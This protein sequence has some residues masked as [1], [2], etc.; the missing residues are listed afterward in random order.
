MSCLRILSPYKICFKV[1]FM[2]S[3]K[4]SL[5]IYITSKVDRFF[6]LFKPFAFLDEKI[7]FL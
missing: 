1:L 6:A 3:N 7:L 4:R 2:R 5:L